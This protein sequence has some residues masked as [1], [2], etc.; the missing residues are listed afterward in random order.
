[1]S[2]LLGKK[3]GMTR[4]FDDTGS[5]VPVTVIKAGPCYVTQIRSK[6]TDGY[7]AVQLG[8][9]PKKEKNI[10]RPLQGHFK[11]ANVPTLRYLSEV[12]VL[13]AEEVKIG[14]Q[15]KVDMF[16]PGDKVKIAG[17]SKGR[18]FTGV[19]KRHGFSGGQ[20]THGQSDRFRAPGSIG[21]SS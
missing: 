8:F 4:I 20:R 11:K 17:R 16:N 5:V 12:P 14:D 15:L 2:G 7:N 3:I 19:I 21:Q 9:E 18:G 13:N 1:M 10:P 6:E